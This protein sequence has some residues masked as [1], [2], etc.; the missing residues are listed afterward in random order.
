MTERRYS[1]ARANRAQRVLLRA[2]AAYIDAGWRGGI[3]G[4][5]KDG[6]DLGVV[7]VR[8]EMAR[9]IQAADMAASLRESSEGWT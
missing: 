3:F 4:C 1:A 9:G 6:A 2:L 7:R 8:V 5:G